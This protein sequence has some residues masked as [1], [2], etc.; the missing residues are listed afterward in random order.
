[1][2]YMPNAKELLSLIH[3][4]NKEMKRNRKPVNL[5]MNELFVLGTLFEHQH[6]ENKDTLVQVKD[7][8]DKLEV[9]RPY[10]N[11]VI[12]GL[13]QKELVERVRKP[14]DNKS[15]YLV[16]SKKANDYYHGNREKL[17]VFMNGIVQKL[18]EDDTITMIRI[19]NK[20]LMIIRNE[21]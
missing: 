20:L 6:D 10:I 11:K 14:G 16:L 19:L 15:V 1:M 9:S 4:L 8:S 17:I 18:G 7:L 13:E 21:R 5:N 2:E 12:N 3:D